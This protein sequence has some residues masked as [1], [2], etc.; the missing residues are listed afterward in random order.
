MLLKLSAMP[1]MEDECA[2]TYQK[3][4]KLVMSLTGKLFYFTK[5]ME[6][7]NQTNKNKS[8]ENKYEHNISKFQATCNDANRSRIM[9]ATELEWNMF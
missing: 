7:Q 9:Q 2:S 8:S 3:Q 5:Y 4:M 1:A 6:F